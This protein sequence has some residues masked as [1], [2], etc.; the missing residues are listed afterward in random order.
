MGEDGDGFLST[1]GANR[2][3]VPGVFGYDVGGEEVH[4]GGGVAVA[5]AGASSV[6]EIAV[7][8]FRPGGFDLDA[9][10]AS[11]VGRRPAR[12]DVT[13]ISLIGLGRSGLRPPFR[14]LRLRSGQA[15]A[16]GTTLS[17]RRCFSKTLKCVLSDGVRR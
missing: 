4:A 15:T 1:Q 7:A 13:L 5:I 9:E 17:P 3:D 11:V 12:L 10:R 2:E 8:V 14:P 16:A 6:D